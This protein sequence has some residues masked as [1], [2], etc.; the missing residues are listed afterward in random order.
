MLS[1]KLLILC[2]I[3]I[4]YKILRCTFIANETVIHQRPKDVDVNNY[5]SATTP[6]V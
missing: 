1:M 2:F 6:I 4:N 3:D 5:R